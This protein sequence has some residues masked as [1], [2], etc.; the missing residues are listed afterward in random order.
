M[1]LPQYFQGLTAQL[2][3]IARNWDAAA[4]NE[5]LELA[6]RLLQLRKESDLIVDLWLQFEEKLSHVIKHVKQEQPD[7][8][9]EMSLPEPPDQPEEVATGGQLQEDASRDKQW[10]MYRKGEGFYH[11]RLYQDARSCFA[12]LLRESPDWEMGRL[13]YAHSLMFCGETEAALKEFRLL[14]RSASSPR[15]EAISY[16][17]L[18]CLLAEEGQWLEAGQAF[19]AAL[20]I[21]PHYREAQFN[22][23]LC[24]LEDGEAKEAMEA[25]EAYLTAVDDD[26]EAE[27]LWLQAAKMLA[28]GDPLSVI[29]APSQLQ[30]PDSEHE[31]QTLHEMARMYE[32]KGQIHRALLCYS[33]LR[34]KLP[35]ESWVYQGLAWNTWLIAGIGK[36]L[37]LIKK[38][39]SLSPD[40]LDYIFTYG[41]MLMFDGEV[42]KAVAAFRFI[43]RKQPNHWLAMSGLITACE[44]KGELDQARQLAEPYLQEKE[45][46]LRSLGFY[47]L[48]RI[49]MLEE[50]WS[51]AES[52]LRQ[53]RI[54]GD[55][56]REVPLYRQLCAAKLGHHDHD[57]VGEVHLLVPQPML[58]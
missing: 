37:P 35:G 13:Y 51:M 55:M 21:Q 42:D 47:H 27:A 23:A 10:H 8:G 33:L 9:E 54:T 11:L 14:S 17:A 24:H 34:E 53:V 43:L 18:G 29:Q 4:E 15:V 22:L 25:I 49:A 2:E 44:M 16:N 30:L 19:K 36:A 5:K 6:N 45:E 58:S 38:A 20:E 1:D 46:Q 57:A 41:W 48:G 50:D 52:Y 3:E 56:F 40:Q 7:A 28:T 32:A 26:W 39:V 12:E 31:P